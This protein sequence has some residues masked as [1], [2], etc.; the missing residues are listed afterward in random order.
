L[1]FSSGLIL[2]AGFENG[3]KCS[4]I[5]LYSGG[6]NTDLIPLKTHLPKTAASP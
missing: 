3:K 5:G 6:E 4:G 1:S 2:A